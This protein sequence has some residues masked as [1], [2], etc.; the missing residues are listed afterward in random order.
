MHYI[1]GSQNPA[2]IQAVTEVLQ[3]YGENV[4][5]SSLE[6]PSAV[7]AQPFGDEETRRGAINR[8]SA[9]MQS[10]T[11]AIGIGLEGGVRKVE[12]QLFLCN[13]G[14]LVL[15]DGT[16]F[17]AGGGQIPLPPALADF[18]EQGME[19]GEAVDTYVGRTG[20]R[21]KEGTVGV[22]TADAVSRS[23][24]FVHVMELLMGQMNY[25]LRQ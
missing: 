10:E 6:V 1:L 22:L 25:Y 21:S 11:G 15:P 4:R 12:E 19:L 18:I 8:A 16:L 23:A 14:A 20:I 9:C 2:K 13:W 5:V 3:T 7:S 24:L 17:T